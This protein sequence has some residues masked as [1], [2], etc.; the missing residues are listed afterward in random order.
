MRWGVS[1]LRNGCAAA[2]PHK[3]A[4]SANYMQITTKKGGQHL[5]KCQ[6]L[7]GRFFARFR[8]A[9][10]SGVSTLSLIYLADKEINTIIGKYV[11]LL[12]C[13]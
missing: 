13:T 1:I 6:M 5:T 2:V 12:S 10:C 11:K 7:L 9:G 8:G 3:I 4:Q